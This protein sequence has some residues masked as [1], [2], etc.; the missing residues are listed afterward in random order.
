MGDFAAVMNGVAFRTRHNDYR[1]NMAS[2][3]STEYGA[4]EP[5]PF[6]DVP[7]SVS[8]GPVHTIPTR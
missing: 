3:T 8:I 2:T 4:Y 7:P 6:P 1:L 5:V